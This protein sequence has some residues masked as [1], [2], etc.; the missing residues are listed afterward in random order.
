MNTQ[1]P[2]GHAPAHLDTPGRVL[3]EHPCCLLALLCHRLPTKGRCLT[4]R[5]VSAYMACV[6]RVLALAASRAG[7]SFFHMK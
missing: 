1:P 2:L 5:C 7:S 6:C 3:S 4:G